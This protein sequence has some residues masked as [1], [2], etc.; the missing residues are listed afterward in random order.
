L[1]AL[2]AISAWPSPQTFS[3]AAIPAFSAAA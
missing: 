2:A 3:M 1:I